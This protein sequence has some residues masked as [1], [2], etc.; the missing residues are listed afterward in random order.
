MKALVI[1][2]LFFTNTL[3][4]QM[5]PADFVNPFLGT[6]KGGN[7]VPGAVVP[8]GMVSVSP[9]NN[10]TSY[11]GYKYGESYLYGFGHVHLS[12]V[13]CR[14]LGN[15]VLMPTKGDLELDPVK[16]RSS[17]SQ[18]SAKPGY[19]QSTLTRYGI[20]AEMSA[21]THTGISA[22]TFPEGNGDANI[23]IDASSR[24]T[25][26]DHYAGYVKTLSSTKLEGSSLSGDFCF[27]GIDRKRT[28][29][30][31]M[32][33]SKPAI[34]FG[35]SDNYRPVTGNVLSGEKAGAYYRFKTGAKE[36]IFVKTGISYVSTANAWLNLRQEVPGWDF[37][38]IKEKAF[39]SWNTE[40]SRI[41]VK[42]GTKDDRINFYTGIYH[43][44]LHP[45]VFNDVNGQYPSMGHKEILNVKGNRYT[46]Y[47][48]WDT[49]RNEHPFLSLFYPGR[50]LDMIRSMVDM[51]KESGWFPKWEVGSNETY[52]MV[53]DPAVPVVA[54]TYLKG[55]KDFDVEKAFEGMLKSATQIKD[56]PIRPGLAP[57]L[58][59]GYIPMEFDNGFEMWGPASTSLEYY[60]ADWSL[61]QL[62]RSLGHTEIYNQMMQRSANYK[63]LYDPETGFIRARNSNGSWYEPFDPSGVEPSSGVPGFVEGN[64]WQYSFFVPHDIPGLIQLMG[65]KENF[66][67]KLSECFDKGFYTLSNEPDMAYPYLFNY[68]RG[69]EWRTQQLVRTKIVNN[70]FPGPD[71]LPGNDDCGVTSGL[72]VFSAMGLYPDCPGTNK[73]QLTSPIF[74]EIIFHLDRNF[75]KGKKFTIRAPNNSTENMFIRSLQLNGKTYNNY[76]ISH[77]DIVNGGEM[78]FELSNK[79]DNIKKETFPKW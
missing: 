57:Y 59:Y 15:I 35:V 34:S 44:L 13:G 79:P 72:Y 3:P 20:Q 17:Y 21:T 31:A 27:E 37:K 18:E 63:K 60:Y 10:S 54:D 22:Y 25:D 40:L 76:Y 33:F 77:E 70:Y 9:H 61:A 52:V 50:Q 23:I 26:F 67:K 38:K 41:E 4:S 51:Y 39:K 7:T 65:S 62:A 8:W 75:Y 46:V 24:I 73:Y 6:I 47:S 30:F 29:Y 48:L 14:D 19:Y 71:G 53:G 1:I 16:Y 74:D 68:I 42:G 56:N 58:Q 64:S 55:I 11:A 45:N 36:T 43:M 32:E 49:Y 78:V 12:G 5:L 2:L 66:I 69:E 28:V